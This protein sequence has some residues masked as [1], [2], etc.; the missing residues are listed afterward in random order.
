MLANP[1]TET[2]AN[3][4]GIAYVVS[5]IDWYWQLSK[6]LLDENRDDSKS[7]G[8]RDELEKHVIDLYKALLSYQMK[9]VCSY[10][11]SRHIVFWRDVI[12]LDDWAGTLEAVHSAEK[13]VREDSATYNTE[14][15][16][17]HLDS[18]AKTAKS[19]EE[20]LL[21]GFRQ[22]LQEQTAAQMKMQQDEENKECLRNLC[23]TDP[24]HDK[25]RIE[26]DKGGLLNDLH[27]WVLQHSDF[28]RWHDDDQTRLLWVKGDPGKGKTMLLIGIINELEQQSAPAALAYFFCQGT[29]SRLNN[30]TAVL[31]GL[32]YRLVMQ[33]PLLITHLR[34]KYD[35]QGPGLFQ[36]VNAFVA[37][38][39]IFRAMLCD[40][41]L[42][43]AYIVVDALDECE[44][45]QKQLL[46]LVADNISA[47][48]H[49]K[50]ILSSR[51]RPEIE[52]EL[53]LDDLGMKL[54]LE[55]TQ[56]A[57]QVARAVNAY[58]DFKVSQVQSLKDDD[59]KRDQV[60]DIL[61]QKANGT[62]LW[63]AIVAQEL[64]ITNSWDILR[65]VE[66]VPTGLE[67]L[68]DRMMSQIQQ[69]KR[70]DPEFCR[71]VLSTVVLTYRPLRLAELGAL[72]GL[73]NEITGSMD[74][75]R[76]IVALCGSFLT[77]QDGHVYLI[78]QSVK[79]YLSGKASSTIFLSGPTD[80]HHTIFLRSLETM[81]TTLQKNIYNLDHHGLLIGE[82]TAPDPDPLAAIRYSCVHW[83]GHFCDGYSNSGSKVETIGDFFHTKTLYWLEALSLIQRIGDAILSIIRLESLLRVSLHLSAILRNET[84]QNR[85]NRPTTNCWTLSR[86]YAG[87]LSR[88]DG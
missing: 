34:E 16:K 61:R 59:A 25:E 19:L 26:K 83:I 71:L 5:R 47:S 82:I 52:R 9:S 85:N 66:E 6:L 55:L 11:R 27:R 49:I 35:H 81:S 68:Y 21:P 63:V 56:H 20:K 80:V 3:C 12:K 41:K 24:C 45:E 44:A 67:E 62:F 39:K 30:A 4:E 57:E 8:L 58:I 32:I 17:T 50:W 54:S 60:R 46:N 75:M 40:P 78:H 14:N 88:T 28:R 7:A 76:A 42:T 79:D 64:Q 43:S 22:A 73:P 84:D 31:K 37:L 53:K 48:A 38:S 69:L 74:S 10:Y 33:Q 18:L 72:S 77:I 86:I 13:T 15:I 87:L 23:A 36:D 1:I 29:D 2:R 51:N 70:K 65:V